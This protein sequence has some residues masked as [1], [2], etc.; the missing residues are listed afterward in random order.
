M[1]FTFSIA[2]IW[3]RQPDQSH[4]FVGLHKM[5]RKYSDKKQQQK[6][7]ITQYCYFPFSTSLTLLTPNYPQQLQ[8]LPDL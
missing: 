5:G 4:F 7:V 2:K 6:K 8:P 1:S 3:F